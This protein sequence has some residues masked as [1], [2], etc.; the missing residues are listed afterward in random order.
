MGE[1]ADNQPIRVQHFEN[2]LREMLRR[3]F[4]HGTVYRLAAQVKNYLSSKINSTRPKNTDDLTDD[5]TDHLS[6][7]LRSLLRKAGPSHQPRSRPCQ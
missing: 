6:P 3:K 5:L 7:R 2:R 4:I 1:Y